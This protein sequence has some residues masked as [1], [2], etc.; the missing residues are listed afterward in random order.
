MRSPDRRPLAALAALAV[1]VGGAGC[2]SLS[3]RQT[4]ETVPCGRWQV[5]LGVD[6]VA[7][8]DER[9]EWNGAGPQLELAAR[10]GLGP[11]LDVGGKLYFAG[12][13]IGLK[14]RFRRGPWA[15]A[16]APAVGFARTRTTPV[17]TDALF[18]FAHVVGIVGH[19]LSPRWSVNFGPKLLHDA[20]IPATSGFAD[21]WQLGAFVNLDWRF[22]A[23][24]RWH[25][26]PELNVYRTLAGSEPVDGRLFQGGVALLRDL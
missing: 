1:V 24:G 15:M 18:L 3:T 20:F 21:G 13:E 11:D 6:L 2:P 19:P 26:V 25:L 10:R 9:L 8:A 14:W 17:T 5:G 4:A 12:V 23:G 22:G 16:V 7:G